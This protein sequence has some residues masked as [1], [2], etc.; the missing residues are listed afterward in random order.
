MTKHEILARNVAD[1]AFV[2]AGAIHDLRKSVPREDADGK[3]IVARAHLPR[4]DDIHDIGHR[5]TLA[6]ERFAER[7]RKAPAA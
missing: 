7:K 6:A 5:A 1:A 4:E 2:L 3:G